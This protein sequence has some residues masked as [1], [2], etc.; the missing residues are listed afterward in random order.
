MNT[1]FDV[2]SFEESSKFICY[3]DFHTTLSVSGAC[4]EFDNTTSKSV[5]L[6]TVVEDYNDE[7]ELESSPIIVSDYDE[8]EILRDIA[9]DNFVKNTN[10]SKRKERKSLKNSI[11][12]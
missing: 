9:M 6:P 2:D 3:H 12:N 8:S 4:P 1:C 10:A 5:E 7:I 11:K